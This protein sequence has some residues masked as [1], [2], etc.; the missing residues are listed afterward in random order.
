M[1]KA[2]IPAGAECIQKFHKCTRPFWE[3]EPVNKFICYFWP[4]TNLKIDGKE[5]QIKVAAYLNI[6]KLKEHHPLRSAA[7][8]FSRGSQN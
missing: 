6:N 4:A 8:K 2:D 1:E 3:N 5:K 7:T